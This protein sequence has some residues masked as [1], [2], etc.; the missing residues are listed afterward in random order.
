[1]LWPPPGDRTTPPGR[2]ETVRYVR[3]DGLV[4]VW[5]HRITLREPQAYQYVTSVISVHAKQLRIITRHGGIIHA[6]HFNIDR[7]LR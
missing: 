7:T 6:D 2:I 4:N 1:V 5:G 3:S